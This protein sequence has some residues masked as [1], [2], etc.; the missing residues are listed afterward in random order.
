[1]NVSSSWTETF[2]WQRLTGHLILKGCE[3]GVCITDDVVEGSAQ[4]SITAGEDFTTMALPGPLH[5]V[6]LESARRHESRCVR[7]GTYRS[8]VIW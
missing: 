8:C 1:M 2:V 7:Q 5:T 4:L 6:L 3:L